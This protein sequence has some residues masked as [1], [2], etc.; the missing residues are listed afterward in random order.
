M[1]E[2][3]G[4][5]HAKT[6][7]NVEKLLKKGLMSKRVSRLRDFKLN[8]YDMDGYTKSWVYQNGS[9]EVHADSW[10]LFVLAKNNHP[11]VI[12]D[13][14]RVLIESGKFSRIEV[15]INEGT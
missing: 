3:C 5:H 12:A 2:F 9:Y 4:D 11:V 13:V 7:P 6:F 10:F 8:L 14:Q 15:E 1:I